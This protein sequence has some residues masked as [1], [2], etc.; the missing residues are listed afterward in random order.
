MTFGFSLFFL[1]V[2]QPHVFG[3]RGQATTRVHDLPIRPK[4]RM[5]GVEVGIASAYKGL[6][7]NGQGEPEP[8]DIVMMDEPGDS[9]EQTHEERKAEVKKFLAQYKSR[10]PTDEEKLLNRMQSQ[11]EI[12]R[13]KAPF[14]IHYAYNDN[15][16]SEETKK[17]RLKRHQTSL[18]SA[19]ESFID[20]PRLDWQQSNGHLLGSDLVVTDDD[21]DHRRLQTGMT[22]GR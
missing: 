7:N 17:E 13:T 5:N 8:G 1:L 4:L 6:D 15:R 19:D 10:E 18:R 2:A 12:Q 14:N 16:I 9:E 11:R 20:R 22:G 21:E 3:L